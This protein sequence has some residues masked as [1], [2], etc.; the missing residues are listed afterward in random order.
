MYILL[1]GYIE[2]PD[3]C[4]S[5]VID[6]AFTLLNVEL[7]RLGLKGQINELGNSKNRPQM[8]MREEVEQL[9]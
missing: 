9:Q 3:N 6:N 8:Q 1:K 2:A 4:D 5:E 7:C